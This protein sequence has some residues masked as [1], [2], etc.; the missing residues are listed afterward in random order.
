LIITAA[1]CER[2]DD[3]VRPLLDQPAI[4][5]LAHHAITGSVPEE[6]T[7]TGR[8]VETFSPAS[9]ADLTSASSSGLPLRK[10]TFLR[11]A[12]GIEERPD[13]GHRAAKSFAPR[14]HL[15]ACDKAVAGMVLVDKYMPEFAARVVTSLRCAP[16]R[17][18]ADRRAD[19]LN[20]RP[21]E[22][23]PAEFDITVAT[24]PG[25]ASRP[26]SF[27]FGHDRKQLVAIDQM[28]ALVDQDDPSASP[29]SAM[30]MSRAFAHLCGSTPPA[31]SIRI[32]VMLK[33]RDRRRWK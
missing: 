27:R 8:G 33:P 13:L 17:R 5:A 3:A 31:R 2:C 23:A 1:A 7:A 25:L 24:M 26:S 28:S 12:H 30:P 32:P 19:E 18:V 22:S 15:K 10:R 4:V 11:S 6:R 16:A 21:R 14:Q 20:P 29:S 9:M